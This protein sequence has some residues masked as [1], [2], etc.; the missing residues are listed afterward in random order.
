MHP[1]MHV[2]SR[3]KSVEIFFASTVFQK[4][5]ITVNIQEMAS[6]DVDALKSLDPFLY[7]SIQEANVADAAASVSQENISSHSIVTRKARFS[8]ESHPDELLG[9]LRLL[10]HL[11]ANWKITETQVTWPPS[12]L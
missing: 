10:L 1:D 3:N 2:I 8:L 4:P 12:R 7:H 5:T 11:Q 6:S 9:D